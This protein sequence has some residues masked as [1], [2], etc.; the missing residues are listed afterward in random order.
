MGTMVSTNGDDGAVAIV[1]LRSSRRCCMR[2]GVRAKGGMRMRCAP[3][4]R[5]GE[6]EWVSG[7]DDAV[8]IVQL[9]SSRCHRH[10]VA[11]TSA[12]GV[13]GRV[14]QG[15]VGVGSRRRHVTV[16]STRACRPGRGRGKGEGGV[17]TKWA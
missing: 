16:A 2:E 15:E 12:R 9:R 6:H 14:G 5:N 10:R 17:H 1:R 13:Q 8:A 11:V 3:S 4:G 7:D